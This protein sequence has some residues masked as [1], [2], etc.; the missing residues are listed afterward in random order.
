MDVLIDPLN[1]FLAM[2]SFPHPAAR[3]F[4]FLADAE[5]FPLLGPNARFA[6]QT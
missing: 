6:K 1:V 4:N 2:F 5:D 3:A